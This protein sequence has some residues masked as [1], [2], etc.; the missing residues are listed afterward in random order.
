MNIND[1]LQQNN[2]TKYR[3]AKLSGVSQTTVI[4]ICNGKTRIEKCPGDTLYKL[5]KAFNV[6]MESLVADT[7][8]YRQGFEAF[9]SNTCHQVRQKGD[10][11]FIIETLESGKIRKLYEKQWYLE[12]LYLLAMVDYLSREN[13]LPLCA[14]YADIRRARMRDPVYPTGIITL[15]TALKSDL[16][17]QE[18]YENAIPEF[19]RFNIVENEVRDVR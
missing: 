12:S 3:L 7:M 4:D 2:M 15:S 16:P 14:E 9:K 1:L 19:K 18:S 17:K 6:S 10:L 11:D 5:A 13:D 8:E